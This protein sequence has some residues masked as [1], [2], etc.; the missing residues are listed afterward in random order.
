MDKLLT[1]AIMTAI[2]IALCIF[3]GVGFWS[4]MK[5]MNLPIQH[6]R[7][8]YVLGIVI[9]SF[10]AIEVTFAISLYHLSWVNYVF[11]ALFVVAMSFVISYVA[12]RVYKRDHSNELIEVKR[13]AFREAFRAAN[14]KTDRVNLIFGTVFALILIV[15]QVF[16]Q[17]NILSF[18]TPLVIGPWAIYNGR[19]MLREAQEEQQPDGIHWYTQYKILFG[20]ATFFLLPYDLIMR[21]PFTSMQAYPNGNQLEDVFTYIAVIPFFASAFF[22]L[23]RQYL[24]RRNRVSSDES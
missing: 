7:K 15:S 22:F 4:R 3:M 8:I 19:K 11:V 12:R 20:I 2:T 16:H 9:S 21:G 5:T 1:F 10:L 17:P 6:D 13:T 24:K 23:R 18:A 14:G